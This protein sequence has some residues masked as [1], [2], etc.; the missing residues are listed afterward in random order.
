M[1]VTTAIL[2][3]FSVFSV[4]SFSILVEVLEEERG[5][6][7]RNGC[8]ADRNGGRTVAVVILTAKCCFARFAFY[9]TLTLNLRL[10]IIAR[11]RRRLDFHAVFVFCF[12]GS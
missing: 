9:G 4:F 1:I 7:E 2:N 5:D 3:E 10:L 12:I 6:G 8:D 11:S